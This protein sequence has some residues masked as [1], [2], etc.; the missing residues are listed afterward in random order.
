MHYLVLAGVL[1]VFVAACSLFSPTPRR[2]RKLLWN[3][4][5]AEPTE[6]QG[7]QAL[8]YLRR[9][10]WLIV[11]S[12]LVIGPVGV[13][14]SV[15][16]FAGP[17]VSVS[18]VLVALLLAELVSAVLPRRG[19]TRVASLTRRTLRGLVPRWVIATHLVLAGVAI[20]LALAVLAAQP[21]ADRAAASLDPLVRTG[22][23]FDLTQ[24]Q[25]RDEALPW[26]I[27][28]EVLVSLLLVYGTVVLAM[29]RTVVGEPEVDAVLRARCARIVVGVGAVY[30]AS[31][32]SAA[33]YRIHLVE[34]S[35]LRL[36]LRP[37]WLAWLGA[38]S[39]PL[40]VV[41]PVAGVLAYVLLAT[42]WK[43]MFVQPQGRSA[44]V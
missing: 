10:Y 40:L 14:L 21:W 9:R 38:L 8:P 19:A 26:V 35:A 17:L 25:L 3:W 42:P 16:M 7:A 27:I 31:V 22:A 11:V 1:A 43:L 13:Q 2:S 4:G 29:L 34:Q 12:V 39:T 28:T 24:A 41:V 5:V 32:A 20:A 18:S 36:P 44:P 33:V 37:D 30:T 15:G 23:G 6:E